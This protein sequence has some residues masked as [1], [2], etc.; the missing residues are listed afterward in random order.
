MV[1]LGCGQMPEPNPVSDAGQPVDWSDPVTVDRV[2][3]GD[4]LEVRR[5]ESYFRV[6]IKGVNTPEMNFDDPGRQPEPFAQ[7]AVDYAVS[8]VG[9]QVG[10][11]WDSACTEPYG[12]CQ[13]GVDGQTCFDRYCRKLAYVRLADGG[14]LG[15]E[16]LQEGLAR[17]YRFGNER[18]D[19]LGAYL[20][21]EDEARQNRRGLWR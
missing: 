11:E 13:E 7:A 8:R 2:I 21:A 18:F 4:T 14:D 1:L 10:L 9:I 3:D 16:L 17:L 5:A 20:N 19:R 6:R 15:E 12:S